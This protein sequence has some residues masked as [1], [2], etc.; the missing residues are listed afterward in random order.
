M[1]K[2]KRG[3]FPNLT[4]KMYHIGLTD[5]RVEGTWVWIDG[6]ATTWMKWG[7]TDNGKQPNGDGEENC[8]AVFKGGWIDLHC[9]RSFPFVCKIPGETSLTHSRRREE[10]MMKIVSRLLKYLLFIIKIKLFNSTLKKTLS[11]QRLTFF[12][13]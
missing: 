4:P 8:A 6:T 5:E 3:L 2:N 11:L 10:T 13:K 1:Q 12:K 9:D 7:E